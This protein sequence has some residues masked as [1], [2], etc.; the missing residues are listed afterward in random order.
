MAKSFNSTGRT[1]KV[2][3]YVKLWHRMLKS[4]AWLAT[5]AVERATYLLLALRYNGQNNG[6][7]SL[8]VREIA[9]SLKIGK[10]TASLATKGLERMGFIVAMKKGA[11]SRKCRHATE[12]RLTEHAC[13][14]TGDRATMDMM[15]WQNSKRSSSLGTNGT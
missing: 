7:I 15:M 13:D 6:M 11:F 4:E 14:V 9:A 3:R 12:W 8:S 5:N 2:E 1:K 10:S